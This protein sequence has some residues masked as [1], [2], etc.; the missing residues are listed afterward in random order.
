VIGL[1]L[2]TACG[3]RANDALRSQARQAQLSQG[4]G[5][6]GGGLTTGGTGSGGATG[7]AAGTTGGTTGG[8]AT[9]GG[10][11]TGGTATGGTTGGSASTAGGG[12][13]NGNNGGATDTGVTANS[14][15]LGI[16]ADLSGPIPGL[17]QGAVRGTQAYLAKVNSEGGVFGRQLKLD[18]GDSQLDCGQYKAQTQDKVE[19]DFAL[20]GSFSL[21]D[22]CGVDVLKAHPTVSDVHSALSTQAQN[23]NNNF[24]VAPLGSG[25]RTGP[26]TYYKKKF[27]DAWQHIGSIY[28]GVGGGKQTWLAAKAVIQKPGTSWTGHVSYDAAY[29]PTDTDFTAD[30]IR[31][32][33]NGV[34][35]IYMIAGDNAGDANVL[36]A[37]R[38]Q[39]SSRGWPV[40]FGGSAYDT[41]FL[42]RAKSDLQASGVGPTYED[43]QYAMFFNSADAQAIPAVKDF[44]T[45]YGRVSGGSAPD[46][47]AAYGWSSAELVVQALKAAGPKAVRKTL[48]DQLKKVHTF[49]AG[50]LLAPADPGRNKPGNCWIFSQATTSAQWARQDSPKGTFRCD[51]PYVSS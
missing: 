12:A 18:V 26:L 43:Q 20:V 35:M 2:V 14:L 49:G 48:F 32:Q 17:F 37:V 29:Q 46:L 24:S 51:G 34:K 31:M 8:T 38:Q 6:G 11:T 16:V 42:K 10:T 15:S 7:G 28:A 36:H 13:F 22:S 41:E 4:G 9:T 45:W 5:G 1:V 47:F 40:V 21:Y 3:S 33:R 30:I 27:G 25:W 39:A 19:H 44:Q 23:V 50:G